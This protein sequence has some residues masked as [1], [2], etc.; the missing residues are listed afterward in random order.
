MLASPWKADQLV[1]YSVEPVP[2]T[3]TA[4]SSSC[5]RRFC[6]G[7][8]DSTTALSQRTISGR[9]RCMI[10]KSTDSGTVSASASSWFH[11]CRRCSVMNDVSSSRTSSHAASHAAASGDDDDEATPAPVAAVPSAG[12]GASVML[13]IVRMR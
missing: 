1:A 7:S 8:S 11:V 3:K 2:A 10:S 9:R 12:E 6:V 5:M 13:R 4:W